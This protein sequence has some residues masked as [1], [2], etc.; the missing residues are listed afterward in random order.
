M[1]NN[2]YFFLKFI[3]VKT[4]I[5]DEKYVVGLSQGSLLLT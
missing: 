3:A 1:L 5:G 2:Y 4:N